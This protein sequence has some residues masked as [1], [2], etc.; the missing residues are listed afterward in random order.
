MEDSKILHILSENS[1]YL[2]N[3]IIKLDSVLNHMMDPEII[4]Q[5]SSIIHNEFCIHIPQIDMVITAEASGIAP[6]FCVAKLLQRPLLYARKNIPKTIG[7]NRAE[8]E[9]H[10]RTKDT[11]TT[12]C[13]SKEHLKQK[14]NVL[15]VDDILGT[16]GALQGLQELTEQCGANII[17]AAFVL[18]KQFEHA[19]EKQKNI[20]PVFSFAK[21][22]LSKDT[23]IWKR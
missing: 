18:E 17:G 10:S 13:I 11:K 20:F 4:W 3:G 22:D 1:F 15:I 7:V 14:S 21:V 5:I 23:L 16:G 12:L 6:A 9:I 19:R 2:G 8:T